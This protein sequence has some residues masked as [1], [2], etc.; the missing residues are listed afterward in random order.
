MQ[1][2]PRLPLFLLSLAVLSVNA[3]PLT[4]RAKS[5]ELAFMQDEEP[6]MR[7]AFQAARATLD[8]S[9]Q[10]LRR[11]LQEPLRMP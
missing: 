9:W 10:R 6:A 4:E 3:Q 8:D 1:R 5:D 2:L 11:L 7:N